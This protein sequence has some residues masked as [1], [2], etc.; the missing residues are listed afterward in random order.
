MIY[1]SMDEIEVM[2]SPGIGRHWFDADTLRFFR[3]RLA[4]GGY[5]AADG[6][7]Y[8]VSSEQNHGMG[9]PYPRLYTV[10]RLSGPK[11]NVETVGE[12]QQY[13]TT[14]AA[15]AAAKGYASGN[16]SNQEPRT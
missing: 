14:G 4:A 3:G 8:F 6:S 11:G 2:Y 5:Q 1:I 7:V 16:L 9:A 13:R 15:T 12:F 10:R